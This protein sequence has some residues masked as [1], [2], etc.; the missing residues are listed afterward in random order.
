[1]INTSQ[2]NSLN[3]NSLFKQL[4]LIIAAICLLQVV[5]ANAADMSAPSKMD[6]HIRSLA[7]ICAACHGTQGNT[8]NVPGQTKLAGKPA[9]LAGIDADYFIQQMFAFRSDERIGTVMNHHA[10]G[11]NDAEIKALGQYY[12]SQKPQAVTLPQQPL[13]KTHKN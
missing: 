4:L 12:A 10:K 11:L 1:M 8:L 13:L 6:V 5:A 9:K 2:M 7:A 3:K